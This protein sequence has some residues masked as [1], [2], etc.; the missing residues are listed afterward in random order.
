MRRILKFFWHDD[1]PPPPAWNLSPHLR[2]ELLAVLSEMGLQIVKEAHG[3]VP[4]MEFGRRIID[5]LQT[6]RPGRIPL[7]DFT[8]AL[9]RVIRQMGHDQLRVMAPTDM[10]GVGY[11]YN[12][13]DP[14]TWP[15]RHES[16]ALH[17]YGAQQVA[18]YKFPPRKKNSIN[19]CPR[20]ICKSD[21]LASFSVY[22][23]GI[24]LCTRVPAIAKSVGA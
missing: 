14:E 22:F 21:S 6:S 9:K 19:S 13:Q 16:V 15:V 18:R 7:P 23:R 12:A 24:A 2:N 11:V 1:P 5:R 20:S 17:R 10:V 3:P 8:D 4:L